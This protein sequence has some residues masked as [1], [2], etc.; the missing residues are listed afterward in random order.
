MR[1]VGGGVLGVV[2]AL[3][4]WSRPGRYRTVGLGLGYL[5]ALIGFTTGWLIASAAP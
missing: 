4:M 2:I 5:V 1:P 3:G